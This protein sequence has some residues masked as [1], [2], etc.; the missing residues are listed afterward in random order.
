MRQISAVADVLWSS[1]LAAMREEL[2]AALTREERDSVDQ[3][4]M[5][6]EWIGLELERAVPVDSMALAQELMSMYV[7]VNA[8]VDRHPGL[9]EAFRD[10]TVSF[11][12]E[13]LDRVATMA[14]AQRARASETS[15]DAIALDELLADVDVARQAVTMI[16][17][18]AQQSQ[19]MY[20][21]AVMPTVAL[22]HGDEAWW[23]LEK[24]NT[25]MGVFGMTPDPR[26]LPALWNLPHRQDL[27]GVT[28]DAGRRAT[29][30]LDLHAPATA[31]VASII[32]SG[33]VALMKVELG[34][35]RAGPQSAVLDASALPPGE[36]IVRLGLDL[37][38]GL[39]AYTSMMSIRR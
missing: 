37:P 14:R 39:R 24:F 5:R 11:F 15:A 10:S 7:R 34:A 31:S 8:I 35:L 17:A 27:A 4:R 16:S 9:A 25:T 26:R 2:E 38:E 3:L 19:M 28:V 6:Y 13:Y 20:E 36:Y 22:Y 18:D 29:L 1:R 12:G 33:G 23:V 32:D 30:E 21:M